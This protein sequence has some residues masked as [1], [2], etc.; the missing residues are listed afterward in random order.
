MSIGTPVNLNLPTAGATAK[1]LVKE[2]DGIY[3]LQEADALGNP[4]SIEL[5]LR[6]S[7][8]NSALNTI[9]IVL[10]RD[11]SA[12]DAQFT[13]T[14]GRISLSFQANCRIGEVVTP[15]TISTYCRYLGS[16]LSDSDVVDALIAGSLQ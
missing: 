15:T 5:S 9:S 13:K 2:R 4:V 16:V 8:I 3:R 10:K 6:A 1:A 14:Q 12:Y 11:P 7:Q